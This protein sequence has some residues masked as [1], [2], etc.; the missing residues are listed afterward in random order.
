[1]DP[2]DFPGLPSGGY[3]DFG[4]MLGRSISILLNTYANFI[5]TMQ[6]Q[7]AQLMDTILTPV[8]IELVSQ[9]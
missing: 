9:R 8:S 2:G 4:R 3:P 7:A 6:D 5:P 1:L